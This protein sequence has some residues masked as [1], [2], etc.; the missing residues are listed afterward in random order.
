MK[1]LRSAGL[2]L[3]LGGGL[4]VTQG[5]RAEG[6]ALVI[7]TGPYDGEPALSR[8][9]DKASAVAAMLRQRGLQVIASR[10]ASNS[11]LREAIEDFAAS[12]AAAPG[13]P[14]VV[15][16][17]A[18]ADAVAERV[19]VLPAD[20]NLHQPIRPQTQGVVLKAVLEALAG[21]RGMV[22]ADLAFL[23]S[24][25]ASGVAAAV[26]LGLPADDTLALVDQ[27][28]T[29]IGILGDV[30][31]AARQNGW[32]DVGRALRSQV[33]ANSGRRLAM[34]IERPAPSV[35]QAVTPPAPATAPELVQTPVA[36]ATTPSMSAQDTFKQEMGRLNV[37]LPAME[38][39]AIGQRTTLPESVPL[40]PV[41]PP[42]TA[43][44]VTVPGEVPATP[45]TKT[46]PALASAPGNSHQSA[47]RVTG[48]FPSWPGLSRPSPQAPAAIVGPD[49]PGHD[50][51]ALVPQSAVTPKKLLGSARLR[52]IQEGLRR[53]GLF[54]DTPDGL[55]DGRTREAVRRYQASIGDRPTGAL[56]SM[57]IVKLLNGL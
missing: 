39:P 27:P 56:T 5:A 15:Y 48:A 13:E 31:I 43:A 33:D 42:G 20:V 47:L 34:L 12:V 28:A 30:L 18:M 32:A 37:A 8:C 21:A 40:N 46:F 17:C 50:D 29:G 41:A 19:F 53:R 25:D 49:K 45:D 23:E 35:D 54:G 44:S 51:G 26:R 10:D 22:I 9:A 1:A 57:Q 14:A 16:M 38:R 3:L 2:M 24:P 52:R 11:S 6:S 7:G 55:N 4:L 36:L